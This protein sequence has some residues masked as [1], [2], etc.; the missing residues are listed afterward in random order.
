MAAVDACEGQER[1]RERE[2]EEE[3]QRS[4]GQDWE[5]RYPNF[6][7]N[8]PPV[9]ASIGTEKMERTERKGM[10]RGVELAEVDEGDVEGGKGGG[11]RTRRMSEKAREGTAGVGTDKGGE[12]KKRGNRFKAGVMIFVSGAGVGIERSGEIEWA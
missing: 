8:D 3:P 9:F 5:S 6:R 2:K 4:F 10:K 11:K 12:G 1:E 7:G